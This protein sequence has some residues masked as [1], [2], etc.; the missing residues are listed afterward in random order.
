[1]SDIIFEDFLKLEIRA[2]TIVSAER[3]VKSDK[4]IKLQVDFGEFGTRQIV[5]GIGKTFEDYELPNT[6]ILAVV[7]LAPRK[8]M[9]VESHGMILAAA[10]KNDRI[11]L[12][13]CSDVANGAR[14]G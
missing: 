14:V 1:M 7:N 12:A 8:L 9:G 13:K 11:C 4:L 5:A 3:I 6:R 2:G 10:D